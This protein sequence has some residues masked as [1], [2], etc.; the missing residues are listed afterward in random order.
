MLI[1]EGFLWAGL[2]LALVGAYHLASGWNLD[3]DEQDALVIA[4]RTV[5][6]AVGHASAQMGW[7]GLRSRPTW[8]ILL[9]SAEN[10]PLRRGLVLVDGVDG[11]VVDWFAEDNP[12]DWSDLEGDLA[13][14][15]PPSVTRRSVR[16][17]PTHWAGPSN[18]RAADGAVGGQR[19][20]RPERPVAARRLDRDAQP[21][22]GAEHRGEREQLDARLHELAGRQRLRRRLSRSVCHGREVGG[23]VRGRARGGSRAASRSARSAPDRRAAAR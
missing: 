3:V 19:V 8:R 15:S 21:R 10:P 9:Y 17:T 7:R 13:G 18:A 23:H 1:N 20:E 22:P 16:Q 4:T 14:T 11:E 2:G 5:G 6:F 12:E